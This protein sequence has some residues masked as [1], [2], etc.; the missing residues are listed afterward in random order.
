MDNERSNLR[1]AWISI[2]RVTCAIWPEEWT[3]FNPLEIK[4][5]EEIIENS[6]SLDEEFAE[7]HG[8]MECDFSVDLEKTYYILAILWYLKDLTGVTNEEIRRTMK[9]FITT[10]DKGM[11]CVYK[12]T[13]EPQLDKIISLLKKKR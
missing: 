4:A 7:V 6:K 10:C 3:Q 8:G 12:E 11:R 13:I 9:S 1:E 2:E 5:L